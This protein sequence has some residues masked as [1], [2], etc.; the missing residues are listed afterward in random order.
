MAELIYLDNAATTPLAPE[1]LEAMLP[2]LQGLTGNPSSVHAT[3]RR[4]RN[5]SDRA[6]AEIAAALGCSVGEIV[7]TSGGTESDNLALAGVMRAA[8]R[9][10]VVT[11]AIEHHAVLHACEALEAEGF[12]VT[13]LP[14]DR[15]GL[16]A[17]ESLR[18]SLRP[19]TVLVSIML[20]NNE[21]GAVQP[22]VE[23]ARI[24]HE[25]GVLF[26][27]DAVQAAG[28]LDINVDRLE[29]DLLSLSAHKFQGPRG[30]GL[31]Y[32]KEGVSV[33]PIAFGGGQEL[34]RRS[35]TENVAGLVGM[36]RALALAQERMPQQARRFAELRDMLVSSV[37]ASVEDVILTGHPERRL[38]GNASFCFDGVDAESLVIS[39]DLEGIQASAGSA[40]T[41]GS[42]QVSHVI[43][44]LG[45][46][47]RY[48]A[49]SLRLTVGA[50]NDE[51]QI[52]RAA[53]A[54]CDHVAR[55]RSLAAEEAAPR[56]K[57]GG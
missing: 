37:M 6:R 19:D 54:V 44:A 30:V 11:S 45:L 51:E 50:M 38:P 49:G 57:R 53:A 4:A 27:T 23:L 12:G 31:L 10:H 34:G 32:V 7:L 25:R 28:Q 3:G 9:G 26:H 48:R 17:P 29:V 18:V 13:Y 21:I 14:V 5:A 39:L 47:A 55:L 56:G 41:S 43:E 8:G 40:C 42:L 16:V 24:A 52:G 46:P 15:Y 35:G 36:A 2:F 22:I 20:A 33:A 1:A